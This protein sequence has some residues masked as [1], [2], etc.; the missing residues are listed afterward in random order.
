M[1]GKPNTVINR[2]VHWLRNLSISSSLSVSSDPLP[3]SPTLSFS[4]GDECPR[5]S[6]VG[7][8]NVHDLGSGEVVC[9][10]EDIGPRKSDSSVSP[11]SPTKEVS[12]D[13][14]QKPSKKDT[15][16]FDP[17]PIAIM[18]KKFSFIMDRILYEEPHILSA[19]DLI[20]AG[21]SLWL[22]KY[23]AYYSKRELLQR[24]F[25]AYRHTCERVHGGI[26]HSDI[27][28][29]MQQPLIAVS[30]GIGRSVAV[31]TMKCKQETSNR[32]HKIEGFALPVD[33]PI[34]SMCLLC[35]RT[36]ISGHHDGMMYR[37][38]TFTGRPL[39]VI[40]HSPHASQVLAPLPSNIFSRAF[41][42]SPGSFDRDIV[43]ALG[44]RALDTRF[45]SGGIDLGVHVWNV[46]KNV[47]EVE[48]VLRG[49]TD[50][51]TSLFVLSDGRV[52]SGSRDTTARV[53]RLKY[54]YTPYVNSQHVALS[55]SSYSEEE[56]GSYKIAY[57][58]LHTLQGHCMSVLCFVQL[59]GTDILVS[60][61]E[62]DT[63][64]F[65]SVSEPP[66]GAPA[67]NATVDVGGGGV[68]ADGAVTGAQDDIDLNEHSQLIRTI[69][70]QNEDGRGFCSLAVLGDGTTLV[71]GKMYGEIIL[72]DSTSPA[73]TERGAL[74][75][76]LY[77]HNRLRRINGLAVL[78]DGI[79]F[80]SAGADNTLRVWEHH[81]GVDTIEEQVPSS[82][83]H[84][85]V[86][87]Y[88]N[89]YGDRNSYGLLS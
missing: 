89:L 27:V 3:E 41:Y 65:W 80:I 8:L 46:D 22:L 63:L 58:C 78:P 35:D 70:I 10:G 45:L 72:I 77:G 86:Y 79:S 17:I 57:E 52:A 26:A 9:A 48:I 2:A 51:I 24:F 74:F 62:D 82:S 28:S 12:F 69:G 19:A 25:R 64:K 13:T 75:A 11:D 37:W 39:Q 68:G 40:G 38:C 14:I 29:N 88:S 50:A 20:R 84:P 81:G 30:Y 43:S 56:T 6:R 49:H 53:W 5:I 61:S 87:K 23:E 7:S 73:S 66:T 60:G 42:N 33:H 34:I 85:Y 32:V 31:L 76:E 36:I 1:E 47:P 71:C 54:E 44:K 83:E 16:I 15:I 21:C 67:I 55:S 59:P 18:R 4:V